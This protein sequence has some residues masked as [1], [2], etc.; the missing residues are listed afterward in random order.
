MS[1]NIYDTPT[2]FTNYA[3]LQRSRQGLDGAPEWPR[4]RS[5]LPASLSGTKIL[6][7]ACGMGWYTR[8]FHAQG[9]ASVL[10]IDISENMLARAREMTAPSAEGI[11]YQRGDLDDPDAVDRLIPAEADGEYDVVFSALAVHYLS[12]LSYLVNRVFRVLKPGGVFVFSTEHPVFTAPSVPGFVEVPGKTGDVRRVWPL[13]QYQVE[14]VRVTNWLA[15]GVRKYHR[16][17][18]TYLNM[19]LGSG[20]EITGFEE[21]YPTEEEFRERPE[22]V[23]EMRGDRAKPTFLLVRAKKGL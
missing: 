16:T 11:T 3:S 14:G 21:W 18:G 4:L 23:E 17:T 5:L 12:N 6:D 20:F 7:L 19:L 15:E 1:Q 2:F 8:Y 13:D 10:A 9:A 22:W